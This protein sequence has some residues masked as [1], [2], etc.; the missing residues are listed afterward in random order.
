MNRSVPAPITVVD[1]LCRR[2]QHRMCEIQIGKLG[3]HVRVSDGHRLGGKATRQQ[4]QKT[5]MF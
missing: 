4:R 3:R 2:M 1:E 5:M